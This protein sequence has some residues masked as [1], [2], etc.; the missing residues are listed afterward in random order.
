MTSQNDVSEGAGHKDSEDQIRR[1]GQRERG[2]KRKRREEEEEEDDDD[3]GG[4]WITPSNIKQ[5]KMDTADWAAP[6]DVRVGCLTTDFAMQI[7][8]HVLSVNGMLIKQARNYILRC[9]ACFKTTSNM[10]KQFCPHCGNQTLKKIAVTLSEDGSMHMHFSKNPK[11]LRSQRN[12]A[13]AVS[14]SGRE[15]Q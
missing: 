13:H 1:R 10:T 11:V 5:V 9:H 2:L 12:E 6:A 3:D 7:G 14:S 4:G 15:A 8:L